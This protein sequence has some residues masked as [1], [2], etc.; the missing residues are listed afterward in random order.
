MARLN[1][2]RQPF[3]RGAIAPGTRRWE[4]LLHGMDLIDVEGPA[5]EGES[6]MR[7]A[8]FANRAALMAAAGPGYRPAGYFAFELKIKPAPFR[9]YA[10]LRVLLEH[11]LITEGEARAIER[12]DALLSS[13]A[14]VQYSAYETAEGVR[15]AC[16]PNRPSAD[17]LRYTTE[18]LVTAAAWHAWRGRREIAQKFERRASTI[19]LVVETQEE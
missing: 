17:L 8:W 12:D 11:Q 10:V 7:V 4:L 13:E 3:G 6:E 18:T 5:F 14:G 16:G 9:R 2:R 15:S 1:R 19:R